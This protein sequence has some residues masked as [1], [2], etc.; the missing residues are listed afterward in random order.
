MSSYK[1]INSFT[2]D[3]SNFIQTCAN[4]KLLCHQFF[5]F[6]YDLSTILHIL[7]AYESTDENKNPI[8]PAIQLML[9]SLKYLLPPRRNPPPTTNPIEP[10]NDRTLDSFVSVNLVDF[11]FN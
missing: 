11:T 1:N 5:F 4:K 3:E 9:P 8:D 10:N 2:V 7:I 6:Y